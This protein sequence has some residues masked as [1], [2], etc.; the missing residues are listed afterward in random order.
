MPDPN[1]QHGESYID[2]NRLLN[3]HEDLLRRRT[4]LRD[5]VQ[6]ISDSAKLW[7]PP[8]DRTESDRQ[9]FDRRTQELREMQ[10]VTKKK[11]HALIA[12]ADET[13]RRKPPQN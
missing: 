2:R 4:I 1:G 8:V 6:R 11:M 12:L 10:A 9:A 5:H 3:V 7:S 13:F